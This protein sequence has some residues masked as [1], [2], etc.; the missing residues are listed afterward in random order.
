MSEK[1][2]LSPEELA[3]ELHVPVR[4]IYA[5]RHKGTGP[6]GLRL[7]RH[8]RFRRADVEVWLEAQADRPR[9]A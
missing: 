2:F 3:E 6:K 5:W 4:S 8:V 9:S 1:E 7:G